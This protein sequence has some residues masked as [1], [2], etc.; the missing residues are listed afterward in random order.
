MIPEFGSFAIILALCFALLQGSGP[1]INISHTAVRGQC[2][3]LAIA[4]FCLMTSLLNNDLTVLYVREHSH[5]SLPLLY[6]IGA[7]WGGHEGSLL[8]WCFI[9]SIWSTLFSLFGQKHISKK[10]SQYILMTLGWISTGFILFLLLTSNPFLRDFP[11]APIIGN[12]LTPVLQ[13]PGL[14][15]HPPVLY[16]GYVGCVMPF[17]FAIAFL[18][19]GKMEPSAARACRPWVILP[20]AFLG[21]GIVSGSWWAYRELG[22]GGWWF[23][24]PVEN[25]SL[26][27]WLSAAALLHSLIVSEK[28]QTFMGWTILLAI[29]T[30]TL[31]LLGTF[32][33]R[34]GVLVSV[35]AFAN[36]P[37]RGL[38]LLTFLTILIGGSLLLYG[39]RLNRFYQPVQFHL[40][41][42][43]T[44]LLLN[45]II[46]LTAIVTIL[47]GT[48]YPIVLDAFDLGKISVGEPYFNTIFVPLILFLLL[49]MGAAPHL[50]WKQDSTYYVLKTLLPTFLISGI[51]V[52]LLA[53][54]FPTHWYTFAGIFLSVWVILT[55]LQYAYQKRHQK[56]HSKYYGMIVAHLGIAILAL[57]VTLNKS[58][59]AE[60]QLRMHLS[61]STEF[62]HYMISFDDLKTLQASNYKG[63]EALFSVKKN[64][65]VI[66]TITAEQRIYTSH[67]ELL[68]HPGILFNAWRDLYV[69]LGNQFSDESWSIRLYYRPFVRWIWAG[70]LLTVLGGLL[71]WIARLKKEVQK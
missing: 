29:I 21:C 53:I 8:M 40:F 34:S 68:S 28:R 32:L 39:L 9:L 64:N 6:R 45:T 57:G 36:D 16:A 56:N 25:A 70:G 55:T 17:A 38:F 61:E 13:D 12:D 2:L 7:T 27:P 69:A 10:L 65:H 60:R 26:L 41:S 31:S 35:H 44:F 20:W 3:F 48:L 33:V 58:Y 47:I 51:I 62:N 4:F 19:T 71:A 14:V 46:L 52:A 24:D 1:L 42:R 49:C 18:L 22:W 54:Y 5:H 23:W 50:K 59:S 30:F 43:E 37:T 63:L 66:G 15:F 67:N 11:I